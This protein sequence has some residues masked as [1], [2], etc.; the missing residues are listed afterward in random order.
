VLFALDRARARARREREPELPGRYACVA[1]DEAQ[2]FAPLELA[3][4]GRALRPGGTLV[5][6]GDAGQQVDPTA[7]FADWDA[8]MRDLG[9]DAHHTTTLETLY[10]S[11]PA[12]T[13]LARRVLDPRDPRGAP[14]PP[15]GGPVTLLR[16]GNECHL[17]ARVIDALRAVVTDDGRA[18]AA[19]IARTPDAA[20]RL[21]R[22]IARGLDVR[23]ALEGDFVFG[24]G[25]NVTCVQEVKGLEFDY[26]VLP[27]AT[28]AAYP[29]TGEARRAMY[30]ALT[31]T[32]HHAL[33]AAVGAFTPVLGA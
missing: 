17:V 15:A 3:L 26:V 14:P 24:P 25:V 21:A 32:V 10:R 5:V 23:L 13:A 27:D 16:A 18:S 7:C 9:A 12:I 28:P 4:V 29:D 31:R 2:E 1:V 19:V 30:V 20:T 6:A 11:P 22:L 8:T 33:V